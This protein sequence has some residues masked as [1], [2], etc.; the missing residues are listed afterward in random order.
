MALS[1][2]ETFVGWKPLTDIETLFSD[3]EPIKRFLP[4][5]HAKFDNETL[6]TVCHNILGASDEVI[7][8]TQQQLGSLPMQVFGKQ[9]YILDLLPRLQQQYSKLDP[10]E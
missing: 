7:A 2:F 8:E 4:E 9:S 10:G 6:K 5:K 1:K 3:V